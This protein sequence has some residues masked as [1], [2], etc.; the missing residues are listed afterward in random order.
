MASILAPGPNPKLDIFLE[1][2]AQVATDNARAEEEARESDCLVHYPKTSRDGPAVSRC[3]PCNSWKAPGR[4]GT[5]TLDERPRLPHPQEKHQHADGVPAAQRPI[6]AQ[7]PPEVLIRRLK[8]DITNDFE[9]I[10]ERPTTEAVGASIGGA[11]ARRC[12]SVYCR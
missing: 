2:K 6:M 12:Y 9:R 1:K 7:K 8:S 3:S 5:P 10:Y 11:A 4:G